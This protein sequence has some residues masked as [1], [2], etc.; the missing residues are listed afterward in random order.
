MSRALTA[1]HTGLGALFLLR[2][3]EALRLLGYGPPTAG[4]RRVVRVLGARHLAQATVAS[5][6]GRL[7]AAAD[8][9]HG[10]TC[11]AYAA[12]SPHRRAGLI[13]AGIAFVLTAVEAR[14]A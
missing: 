14:G 13:A 8:G 4:A 12:A 7:G 5:R 1:A 2:P 6:A 10:T 9:L 11:L 3:D